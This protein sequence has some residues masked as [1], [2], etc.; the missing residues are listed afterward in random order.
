MAQPNNDLNEIRSRE[1]DLENRDQ[2]N[3]DDT[4]RA[5]LEQKGSYIRTPNLQPVTGIK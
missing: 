2:A 4:P 3:K 1:E 5:L